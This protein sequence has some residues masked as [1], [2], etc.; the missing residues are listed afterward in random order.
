MHMLCYMP[1]ISTLII[2]YIY[3]QMLFTEV[4]MTY[5]HSYKSHIVPL[6]IHSTLSMTCVT[7]CCLTA[8]GEQD[9]KIYSGSS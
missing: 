5:I 4:F 1:I 9:G 8:G 6:Y 3:Y 7:G 2:K